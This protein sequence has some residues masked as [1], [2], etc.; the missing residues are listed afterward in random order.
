[1]LLQAQYGSEAFDKLADMI[2][3]TLDQYGIYQHYLRYTEYN[4][5]MLQS[6]GIATTTEPGELMIIV[7]H[8]TFSKQLY[9]LTSQTKFGQTN[10]LY[11]LSLGKTLKPIVKNHKHCYLWSPGFQQ[12]LSVFNL[13]FSKINHKNSFR[14]A[15]L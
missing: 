15:V 10:L 12:W 7:S 14:L 11:T 9:H 3:N 1:M 13:I 6:A 5:L 8:Q 2:Y 4:K